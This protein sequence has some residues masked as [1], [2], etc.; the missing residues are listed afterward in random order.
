MALLL[1]MVVRGELIGQW[2]DS[3]PAD[4]PD[5]FMVNIQPDQS[6]RVRQRLT[7]IGAERLQV[8]PMA[9]AQLV[10]I[11]GNRPPEDE[12]T[13]QVNLSWINEMPPANEVIDGEFWPGAGPNGSASRSETK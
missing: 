12:F 7:D 8:R 3:L 6:E 9:N 11:S 10:D 1:L 2:R 5:H 13:G 4:T